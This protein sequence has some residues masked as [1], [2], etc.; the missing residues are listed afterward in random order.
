MG[1]FQ[2][3][4]LVLDAM[5]GFLR[6]CRYYADERSRPASA[7]RSWIAPRSAYVT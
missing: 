6:S 5:A 4:W 7:L 3:C 2:L 1:I